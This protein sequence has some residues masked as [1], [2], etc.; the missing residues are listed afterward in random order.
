MDVRLLFLHKKNGSCGM[1]DRDIRLAPMAGFTNAP[2]RTI[3]LQFGAK[4]VYTEMAGVAGLCHEHSDETWQLLETLPEE[5]GKIWAHLY[6]CEPE[7]FERAAEMIAK[8]GRFVGIDINAG[9]PV[10]KVTIGGAG[11]ALMRDP[12]KIGAI[13]AATRRGSGL[14]VSVKTRIGFNPSEIT[15][16]NVLE[17]V[18]GAG[19]TSIG[20]HGR[21]KSQGHAGEVWH[22]TVAEVKRRAKIK[23]FGNGGI[24]DGLLAKEYFEKTGVDGLL[25]GQ[26]AI[27]HPWI[28]PEIFNGRS[29]TP[30]Q[31]HSHWLSLEEIRKILFQH[32]ESEFEFASMIAKKYPLTAP[33]FSPEQITVI[34]F[35]VHLFRY[36]AGLKGSSYLRGHMATLKSITACRDAVDVCL[37]F[38]QRFRL[39]GVQRELDRKESAF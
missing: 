18:E 36:L 4:A 1:S 34:R 32:I 25:I 7:Y 26:G 27:G 8:T 38:E 15:I 16:F 29:F 20:V 37:E 22:E 30:A 19:A 31:S 5:K 11:S 35:R 39:K 24:R 21:Y 28:F 6:G 3:A 14:P 12:K 2:M 17:E 23:V 13:V 33:N 10:P 9:C